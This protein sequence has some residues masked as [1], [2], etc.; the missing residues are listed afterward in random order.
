MVLPSGSA[1]CSKNFADGPMKM[2]L[3]KKKEKKLE[4]HP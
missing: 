2:V 1:Q 4:A 3:S